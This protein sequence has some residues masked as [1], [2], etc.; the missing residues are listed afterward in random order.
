MILDDDPLA[1]LADLPA[2]RA[3]RAPAAGGINVSEGLIF[4]MHAH[5]HRHEALALDVDL[6]LA[7]VDVAAP[8]AAAAARLGALGA[9]LGLGDVDG[10]DV[11]LLRLGRRRWWERHHH[12]RRR[13]WLHD[14]RGRR[15]W[16]WGDDAGRLLLDGDPAGDG[17]LQVHDLLGT[18][19]V[20]LM[21]HWTQLLAIY[22]ERSGHGSIYVIKEI[23]QE[24]TS[25]NIEGFSAESDI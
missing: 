6:T 17:R 4:G 16:R 8:A 7:A 24:N 5:G 19:V 25:Y 9:L 2:R 10:D 11:D 15:W 1:L 20:M 23:Y 21:N 22:S 3:R 12:R 18:P 13:G 14:D